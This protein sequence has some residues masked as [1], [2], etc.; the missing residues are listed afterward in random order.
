MLE[1]EGLGRP[2]H[3]NG[4]IAKGDLLFEADSAARR[5]AAPEAREALE[6][7]READLRVV[8]GLSLASRLDESL[9]ARLAGRPRGTWLVVNHE[10]GEVSRACALLRERL[11]GAAVVA[12][13]EPFDRWVESGMAGLEGP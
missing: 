13:E 9:V 2:L 1:E 8:A 7:L 6:R 11:A 12:I 4:S 3:L 10:A 5:D